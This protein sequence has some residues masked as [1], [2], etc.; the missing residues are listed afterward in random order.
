MVTHL[1][2]EQGIFLIEK[3]ILEM[4]GKQITVKP[5]KT[6]VQLELFHQMAH[7]VN[8]YYRTRNNNEG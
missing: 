5:P 7:F 4:T 1:T 6:M 2:Q 8:D 3:Y